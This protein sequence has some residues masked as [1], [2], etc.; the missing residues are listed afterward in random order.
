MTENKLKIRF[1]QTFKF[2]FDPTDKFITV[3]QG[4]SSSGKTYSILQMMVIKT[5]SGQWQ[6]KTIDVIR[7]TFPSHRMG[8]KRDFENILKSLNIYSDKIHNKSEHIYKVNSCDFR[9]YSADDEAKMRG[10]RRDIAFFNEVLEMKKMDV[11]QVIM[12]TNEQVYMDFNPSDEFHWVYEDIIEGRNDVLFHKST[13]WDNPFLPRTIINELKNLKNIDYNL[14][15][16]YGLGERGVSEATIYNNWDYWKDTYERFEGEELFGL[17]FGYN[18][19]TAMVRTKIDE[20]NKRMLVDELIYKSGL[21][22]EMIV[23]RLKKLVEQGILTYQSKITAD[24]A[25]PEIIRDIRAAGFNI[26]PTKKGTKSVIEGINYTKQQRLFI[27]EES[28]NLAKELRTYKW[29]VDKDD[30]VLDEP[31]KA[32]D[33]LNDSMRYSIESKIRGG[34]VI[35]S[36]KQ[37]RRNIYA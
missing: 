12:R 3:L 8:A 10:P 20:T 17:D 15:R 25:R 14:W 26:H 5:L 18:H 29:K 11:L 16:I 34:T 1:N 21:T 19:P 37:N 31:V 9:F 36:I 4:S 27:T 35:G 32:N 23:E 24:N 28:I 2:L 7:R 33:D 13:F 6:N 22:S 30:N